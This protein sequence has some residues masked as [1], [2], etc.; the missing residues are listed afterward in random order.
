MADAITREAV[1]QRLEAAQQMREEY[2]A[3]VLRCEGSIVALSELLAA[4]DSD[5]E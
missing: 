3:L 2:A 4:M 5:E 1:E